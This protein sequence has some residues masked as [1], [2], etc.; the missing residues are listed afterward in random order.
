MS[1]KRKYI[2]IFVFGII[3]LIYIL[4]SNYYGSK[5]TKQEFL[6]FNNSKIDGLLNNVYIKNH[7]VGFKINGENE[8]FIFYPYTSDLNENKIF[9]H[10]AKNGDRIIKRPNSDTLTLISDDIEYKYTFQHFD[11]E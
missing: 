11:S 8:E 10:L 3:A 9:D 7:G 1:K 2:I 5:R 6:K 4:T